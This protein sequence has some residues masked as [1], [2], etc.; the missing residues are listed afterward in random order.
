[1]YIVYIYDLMNHAV[2]C[3]YVSKHAVHYTLYYITYHTLRNADIVRGRRRGWLVWTASVPQNTQ[4]L[5]A[6]DAA[7]AETAQLHPVG[8]HRLVGVDHEIVAFT[9][10]RSAAL[11]VA[12]GII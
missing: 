8:A 2:F 11:I 9:C 6:L 1:M 5:D 4:L 7:L 10:F 3:E 12:G